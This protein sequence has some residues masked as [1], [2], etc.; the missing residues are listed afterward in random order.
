MHSLQGVRVGKNALLKGM[1]L[2]EGA[3]TRQRNEQIGGHRAGSAGAEPEKGK[4]PS[5]AS[6]PG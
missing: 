5:H 4:E 3:T 6:E 1:N 2:Q